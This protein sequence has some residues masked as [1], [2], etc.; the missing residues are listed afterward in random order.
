MI[1]AFANDSS[2]TALDG[3]REVW[4][5]CEVQ[6]VEDGV[7]IFCNEH[8]RI[9]RPV[10]PAPPENRILKALWAPS[11]FTLQATEEFR[12]ELLKSISDGA[13]IVDP[14][15]RIRTREELMGELKIGA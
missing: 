12:T 5:Y 3:I 8:G 7:Y 4:A 9:L 13:L 1:L 15:P 6:D 2:V 11:T 14:G 10:F